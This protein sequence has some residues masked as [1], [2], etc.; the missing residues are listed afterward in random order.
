MA[1]QLAKAVGAKVLV[2]AGSE[3]KRKRCR[4]L[5]ADVAVDYHE[6]DFVAAVREATSGAGADVV[7]DIIGAKYLDRNIDALALNGRLVVIGLQGGTR[8]E[9]DLNKLLRKR[10]AVAATSLRGRPGA[11]KAAI[12]AAVREHVWPLLESG[13]V[14][15]VVDRVLPIT[16]A[17]EAHRVVEAGEHVGKVVLS[18]P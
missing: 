1:I 12:V 8:A 10:A 4:E 15:P 6:Q 18:V 14:R 13:R 5:G 9:L 7:L 2:T 3:E 16:E 17:P 11:E